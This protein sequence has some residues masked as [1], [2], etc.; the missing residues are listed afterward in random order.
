MTSG[1]YHVTVTVSDG[2]GG[3]ASKSFTW[4]V[5]AAADSGPTGPVRLNMD[6]KCLDDTGDSTTNG[7]KIQIWT[8]NGRASQNWTYAGDGTLRINGKCL[9]IVNRSGLSG[10]KLQLW[11][12]T[13][14]TNQ[15]WVSRTNAQLIN[16]ASA[17][18][19]KDPGGS[20]VNGTQLQINLCSASGRDEWTL[21]AGPVLS[22]VAGKCMD[23]TGDSTANGTK[24]QVWD[25]DGGKQQNWTFMPDGTIRVA[26]KCLDD[27]G[28]GTA[29]GTK[30]QLW[31]CNGG[32]AQQ[33]QVQ[34]SPGGYLGIELQHGNLCASP[35]SITAAN[36]TQLTLSESCG[37][38]EN[39]WHAR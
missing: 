8:C 30:I 13:Q 29:S 28:N 25:C 12:C 6:D 5:T 15:Q 32:A 21:P 18:C 36:G 39:A 17:I 26:G 7:T 4:T 37:A 14:G 27:T 20:T 24:I 11:S 10:A 38:D 16:P 23:D 3:T 31:T 35:T 22:A 34:G 33:W 9:D 1:T 2:Y 19:L